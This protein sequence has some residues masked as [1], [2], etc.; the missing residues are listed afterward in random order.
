MRII[1]LIAG[2]FFAAST[3]VSALADELEPAA[4][5]SPSSIV[6]EPTNPYGQLFRTL[7][8]DRLE[9]DQGVAVLGWAEGSLI[10]ANTSPGQTLLPKGF[11][12]NTLPQSFLSQAEGANFNQLGLMVCKGAGCIPSGIFAPN[13]NVLSRVGPLPG[14][15]GEQIL[16]DWNATLFFG[17]DAV[18]QKTKGFDDWHWDADRSNKLAIPQLFFDLYLPLLEGTSLL[19]G[20][21]GTPLENDITYPFTPPNWFV[22]KTY[23]FVHGPA[24][25]VGALAQ[26]KLP[27]AH[28]LGLLS[29]EG[30]V[31]T[32]W[33]RLG[34]QNDDP[35]FLFGARWR[36]PNGKTA[37]DFEGIYGN[38]EDDFGD[39]V[40]IDGIA[41]PLGGGSPYLALS[42][43][44]AY[45]DRVALYLVMSHQFGP[46]VQ[47]AIEATYGRQEGGDIG[48]ALGGPIPP[49]AITEDS[50]WYGLNAALRLMLRPNL[51]FNLR[52]EWFADENGANVLWG[53]VGAG[54][55]NVYAVSANLSWDPWRSLN[56]R[57]EIRYDVYD[58]S[59]HLFAPVPGAAPGS[60]VATKDHQLI[61]ILNAVKK[62]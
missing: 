57:P 11:A 55:G 1:A 53:S 32:G 18:F 56:I 12:E 54:G 15:R 14:A 4:T 35:H 6:A 16:I 23:A 50:P 38:G 60:A 8:G 37:I 27:L 39:A 59:G 30:G 5:E 34:L 42:S 7:F 33:N 19:L 46:R 45:L 22:T 36:S 2:A 31:V 10:E 17:E 26:S 41:R 47:G 3:V 61:G 24:K 43:G 40:L 49:F 21:F 29:I 13:R 20:S 48:F 44:D 52:G 62:F 25:H 9:R 51:H 28:E 58:G